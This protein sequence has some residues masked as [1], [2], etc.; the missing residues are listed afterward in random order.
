VRAV[1]SLNCQVGLYE[2]RDD[3][4]VKPAV[5]YVELKSGHN[6]DG[7]AWIGW[8]QFSKTGR[9]IYYRGLTLGRATA[10]WCAN[11]VDVETG[12]QYWVSGVKRDGQDR[13]WAGY[14][15]VHIDE[16]ARAEY[17]RLLAR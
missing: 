7:P 6:D 5:R 15:Q 11:H 9:S 17:E 1:D 12:D 10:L 8:V 16:D 2:V 4:G 3:A 13:H 14:G